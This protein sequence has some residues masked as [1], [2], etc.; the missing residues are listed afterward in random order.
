[1]QQQAA[2]L[3]GR[4]YLSKAWAAGRRGG[5]NRR[6]S[7]LF[8]GQFFSPVTRTNTNPRH[9]G[10]IKGNNK[11][12][13]HLLFPQNV[14]RTKNSGIFLYSGISSCSTTK[15]SV[16]MYVILSWVLLESLT[17]IYKDA[18]LHDFFETFSECLKTVLQEILMKPTNPWVKPPWSRLLLELTFLWEEQGIRTEAESPRNGPEE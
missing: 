17:W 14:F 1:M 5:D 15:L 4:W 6:I 3:L 12:K 8:A 11:K 16:L 7:V 13:S 9:P 18:K 2:T 10:R